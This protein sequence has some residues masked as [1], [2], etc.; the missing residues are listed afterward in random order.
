MTLKKQ[1]FV[2]QNLKPKED[3]FTVRCNADDRELIN[4]G[5][6]VFDIKSDS[7]ALK[8]LASVGRNVLHGTFSDRF[9][10]YLFKKDRERLTDY[11]DTSEL[12]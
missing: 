1:P 4:W 12:L 6:K 2:K 3:T 9:L 5:K 7:K 11:K 8:A 10:Q